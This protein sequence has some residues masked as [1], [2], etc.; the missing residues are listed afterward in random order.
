MK[1]QQ[2]P[3]LFFAFCCLFFTYNAKTYNNQPSHYTIYTN[4]D[5]EGLYAPVIFSSSGIR[6]FFK[7][8]FNRSEYAQEILPNDFSHFVQWLDRS[9]HMMKNRTGKSPF[10]KN[11]AKE[12]IKKSRAHAKGVIRI[13]KNKLHS[14]LYVNAY[15]FDK[16][17]TEVIEIL[18]ILI[19]SGAHDKEADRAAYDLLYSTFSN[20]FTSFKNDPQQ[21]LFDLSRN[22]IDQINEYYIPES[23]IQELRTMF[24]RF[25]EV[26]LNKLVWH[27]KDGVETWKSVKSIA[28]HLADLVEHNILD[29]VED[30]NDLYIVLLERYIFFIDINAKSL[31][32]KFYRYIKEEITQNSIILLE[33]EEQE[34]F[35]EPKAQR[36]L[37][38]L[39]IAE[40]QTLA[41]EITP[42][43]TA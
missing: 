20:N 21:F 17:L 42:R 32:R 37:N 2:I 27:P 12:N 38:I 7:H 24:I 33:L 8:T 31:P 16:M 18:D 10:Y 28:E 34:E 39:N 3:F 30:L 23:S 19:Q 43:V 15:A 36:F 29:D 5:L 22:L 13:F 1:V 9:A 41:H 40:A 25:L 26:G 11:M 6:N 4:N 35:I 14:C